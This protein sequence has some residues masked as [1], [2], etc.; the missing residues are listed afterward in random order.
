MTLNPNY[1]VFSR[2]AYNHHVTRRLHTRQTFKNHSS[3]YALA[4]NMT[5]FTERVVLELSLYFNP[6]NP[7]KHL[8]TNM[9]V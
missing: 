5:E 6:E 7:V 3:G 4:F 1:I 2:A 8:K 9:K